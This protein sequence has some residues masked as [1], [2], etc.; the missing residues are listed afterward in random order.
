[1]STHTSTTTHHLTFEVPTTRDYLNGGFGDLIAQCACGAYE[2]VSSRAEGAYWH[3]MHLEAPRASAAHLLA[4]LVSQPMPEGW[5]P[6]APVQAVPARRGAE[7]VYTCASCVGVGT[8]TAYGAHG[9]RFYNLGDRA[10]CSECTGSGVT[11]V[12]AA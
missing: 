4:R 8:V 9:G 10:V 1:M 11:D 3:S 12:W 2:Y 6:S 5:E 7:R